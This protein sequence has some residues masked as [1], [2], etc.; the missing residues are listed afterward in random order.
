MT[1]S[2]P[3]TISSRAV[4]LVSDISIR[5]VSNQMTDRVPRRTSAACAG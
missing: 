2:P 5:L 4:S 3:F 1:Y